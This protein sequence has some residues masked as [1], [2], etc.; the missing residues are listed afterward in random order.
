MT[1]IF[2]D[3]GSRGNP[4]P[5]AVAAIIKDKKISK[6]LGNKTNNQAE[7]EAVI[8]AL[9][10]CEDKSIL[11]NL[12]SELVYRQLIGEYKIKHQ[13]MLPLYDKVQKLI[14]DKSVKF[15]LISREKNKKAD[16]LVNKELDRIKD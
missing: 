16:K 7:Y 4:G 1:I 2:T 3:G 5:S 14:K 10:N 13:N 15:N 6:F 8:L 11:I 9:E 12:D